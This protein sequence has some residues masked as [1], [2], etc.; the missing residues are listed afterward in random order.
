MQRTERSQ[1]G[2]VLITVLIITII[3][4]LVAFGGISE[5]R[6]QEQ[7]GGN[8]QKEI[9]ARMLAE[10][11]VFEAFSYIKT[12]D[13]SVES[14]KNSIV[15]AIST[16]DY[17]IS[18]PVVS[19]DM[20][21]FISTGHFRGAIAY[22]KADINVSGLQ[23]I[24]EDAVIGC[25]GIDLSG[26]GKIDSYHSAKG[27]YGGSNV[28]NKASV[29]T[30]NSGANLNL[31]GASPIHGDINVNGNFSST[32]SSELTGKVSATGNITISGGGKNRL[33]GDFSAGGNL[34]LG[35]GLSIGGNGSVVGD[36]NYRPDS[37]INGSL[38]FGG[39]DKS[40]GDVSKLASSVFNHDPLIPAFNAPPCD[41][42]D[43]ADKM[44]DFSSF[45][46]NGVMDTN[47]W[48][49]A[50]RSYQFT[51]GKAEMYDK[52][53]TNYIT[54]KA[55]Q[56]LD[57]LGDKTPVH[58]FDSLS[59]QNGQI[60][61]SGG[62]VV[63]VIKGDFTTSGGGPRIDIAK[64]SSLT[65]YIE[66]KVNIGSSGQV[67]AQGSVTSSG[68]PPFSVFS[69]YTSKN[70]ND[71]GVALAGATDMYASVY[72]PLGNVKVTGSGDILGALRGKKVAISGAGG[73]HYDEA[74]AG[75]GIKTG[76]KTTAFASLQYYYPSYK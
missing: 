46:S 16:Q 22:L 60:N 1:Q 45:A 48:E 15:G 42:M 74:L 28:N 55:A 75:V 20:L 39:K 70:A 7:I 14:I 19:G 40:G 11:G 59:L 43:I 27:Q 18:D 54:E 5:N 76:Q 3:A 6:L 21:S 66:G 36:I 34:D 32:G 61:V 23:N 8:Q 37:K 71:Y 57:I 65:L 24:F 25:E 41:P 50:S 26:S 35:A 53:A 9:N 47:H 56:N 12:A 2:Y 62:D 13:A 10:K 72:A 49:T 58:V 52:K 30:I 38:T 4:T 69:S 68:K 17:T 31:S 64:G 33:T 44:K 73:M 51:P 67:V 29:T 63:L